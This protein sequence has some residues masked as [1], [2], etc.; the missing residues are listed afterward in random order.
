MSK[1]L[2]DGREYYEGHLVVEHTG[3]FA[4]VF[5]IDEPTA[6]GINDGQQVSFLVTARAQ[7]VHFKGLKD[8]T[9][10]KK[11]ITFQLEE[12]HPMAPEKAA[13]LA[14]QL[15]LV[16]PGV[17]DLPEPTLGTAV[18]D[19]DDEPLFQPGLEFEVPATPFDE[20]F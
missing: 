11:Q 16:I 2:K 13:W 3:R 1:E 4:R 7:D 17:N 8:S 9:C 15:S 14:D 10:K 5:D 6:V 19:D 20:E 12:V 18:E